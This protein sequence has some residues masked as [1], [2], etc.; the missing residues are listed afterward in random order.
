[1][2]SDNAKP[3]CSEFQMA[4]K[5][6]N[7]LVRLAADKNKIIFNINIELLAML[8]HKWRDVVIVDKEPLE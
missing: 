5:V 7:T 1:M 2:W 3:D 8:M 6:V 4:S